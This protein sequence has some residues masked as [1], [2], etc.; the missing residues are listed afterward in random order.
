MTLAG[1]SIG[2]VVPVSSASIVN[3]V[4]P[5]A[6]ITLED[7]DVRAHHS[8]VVSNI[9]SVADPGFFWTPQN[10]ILTHKKDFQ[11]FDYMD[12][13]YDLLLTYYRWTEFF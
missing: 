4:I 7:E 11:H 13:K 10:R 6:H 8:A 2:S 5:S 9:A 1:S 3:R 12:V